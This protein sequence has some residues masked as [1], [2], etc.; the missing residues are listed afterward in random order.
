M[1]YNSTHT[2]AWLTLTQRTTCTSTHTLTKTYTAQCDSLHSLY[3]C[4]QTLTVPQGTVYT[5]TDTHTHGSLWHNAQAIA[6]QTHNLLWLN[7]QPI[8][9]TDTDLIVTQCTTY[10]THTH[11]SLWLY[12]QAITVHTHRHINTAHCVSL[13]SLY[14]QTHTQMVPVSYTHL[15]LP[16]SLRV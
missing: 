4:F 13:H 12:P 5:S 16:T 1:A 10:T 9:H 2:Q 14:Q 15:T 3:L 11:E 6:A 7:V 8:Q